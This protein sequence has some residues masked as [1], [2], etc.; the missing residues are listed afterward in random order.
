MALFVYAIWQSLVLGIV[1]IEGAKG[2]IQAD[3]DAVPI[4]YF[5]R[6]HIR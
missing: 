6:E 4:T 1:P 3:I 5:L 2:L